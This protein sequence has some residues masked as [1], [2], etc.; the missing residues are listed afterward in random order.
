MSSSS[1]RKTSPEGSF[2]RQLFKLSAVTWLFPSVFVQCVSAWS[3][4]DRRA[5]KKSLT[6]PTVYSF[7]IAKIRVIIAT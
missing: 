4:F 1:D 7:F 6:D 2:L 5:R 3:L